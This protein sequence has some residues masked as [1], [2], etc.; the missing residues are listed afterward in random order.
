M[1]LDKYAAEKR[2]FARLL[3]TDGEHG[4]GLPIGEQTESTDRPAVTADD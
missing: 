4:S 3:G 2:R 1:A